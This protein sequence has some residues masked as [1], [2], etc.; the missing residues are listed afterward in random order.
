MKYIKHVKKKRIII[1]VLLG[2][3]VVLFIN[4]SAICASK[5]FDVKG[6]D[7]SHHQG[8][9]DWNRVAQ[10]GISFAYIKATEG[11]SLVDEKLYDNYEGSKSTD[12]KVG[13]YHFL[14]F[15][16]SVEDQ[17]ANYKKAI[18]NC[19]MDIIPAIDVEWYPNIRNNPPAKKIVI[20]QIKEMALLIEKEYGTKPLIYTTQSFYFK[21][22][23]DYEFGNSLWIR[24]IYFEPCQE[25]TLWQYT[26]KLEIENAITKGKYIDGDVTDVDGFEKLNW[27][28]KD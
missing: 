28:F 7:V 13:Y 22:L 17:M 23:R 16:S 9:I 11:S 1:L 18:S 3:V 12:I 8:N 6:I 15:E 25:W 5:K 21:Y 27:D 20:N 19:K 26:E 2:I 10:A 4:K 14:S 24:N